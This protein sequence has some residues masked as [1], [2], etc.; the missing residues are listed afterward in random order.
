LHDLIDFLEHL[1]PLHE[2]LLEH[3]RPLHERLLEHLRPLHD[4]IDFLE[5]LRPLHERLLDVL[6][7]DFF[8]FLDNLFF[9]ERIE[10]L[11]CLIDLPAISFFNSIKENNYFFKKNN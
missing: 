4:L 10:R 9:N 7:E 5:H 2:R 6:L 11:N 1:R 3:L 8:D